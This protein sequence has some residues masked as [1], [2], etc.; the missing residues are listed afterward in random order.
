MGTIRALTASLVF[1]CSGA[2]AP[3][4]ADP[5]SDWNAI[6]M[7]YVFGDS[8]AGVPVGRGGP[9]GLLDVALVQVAVHDAVQAIEGRF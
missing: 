1:A 5:V 8:S 6:T 7:M 3:V 9:P 2:A 4:N